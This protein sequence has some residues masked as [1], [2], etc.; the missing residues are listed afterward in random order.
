MRGVPLEVSGK[1]DARELVHHKVKVLIRS[2]PVEPS[3][4]P[5]RGKA[6]T[7]LNGSRNAW[8]ATDLSG[9]AAAIVEAIL[10]ARAS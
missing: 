4:V 9:C 6:M 2:G 1:R 7:I 8:P 5:D 3:F 10:C